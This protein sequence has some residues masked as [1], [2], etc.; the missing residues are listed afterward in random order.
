MNA[1]SFII[2][3]PHLMSEDVPADWDSKPVKVLVGKNFVDVALDEKKDVFVEFCKYFFE[4]PIIF[5]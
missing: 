5:Y 3:Q 2:L 4:V 1:F